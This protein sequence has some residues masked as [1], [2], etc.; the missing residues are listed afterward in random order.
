MGN[1]FY[2]TAARLTSQ[3]NETNRERCNDR[4]FD[5]LERRRSLLLAVFEGDG[6][7][8]SIPSLSGSCDLILPPSRN[9]QPSLPILATHDRGV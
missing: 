5:D 9:N 4:T 3:V 1:A 6:A 7:L 2:R 8:G